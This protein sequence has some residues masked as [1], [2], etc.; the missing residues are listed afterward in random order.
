MHSFIVAVPSHKRTF[1]TTTQIFPDTPVSVLSMSLHEKI[2][3]TLSVQP[4]DLREKRT[5]STPKCTCMG[6]CRKPGKTYKSILDHELCK[7]LRERQTLAADRSFVQFSRRQLVLFSSPIQIEHSRAPVID[8]RQSDSHL[9]FTYKF[10]QG[11]G[12]IVKVAIHRQSDSESGHTQ[13]EWQWSYTGRVIAKVVFVQVTVTFSL[14]HAL[15]F[16]Q[17]RSACCFLLQNAE[18]HGA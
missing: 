3:N 4:L 14:P 1:I 8:H 16:T 2:H 12:A 9:S 18:F 6:S 15:L 17:N 13:V 11:G 10:E 7:V 5:Q